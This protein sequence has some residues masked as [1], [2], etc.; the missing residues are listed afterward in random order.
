MKGRKN[1]NGEWSKNFKK[2]E[3]KEKDVKKEGTVKLEDGECNGFDSWS[4]TE[5]EGESEDEV[6]LAK[7]RKAKL[8]VP[9]NSVDRQDMVTIQNGGNYA[10]SGGY[11]GM[12]EGA[13]VPSYMPMSEGRAWEGMIPVGNVGIDRMEAGYPA[14]WGNGFSGVG[15][16]DQ[17]L[18]GRSGKPRKSV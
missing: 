1:E 18:L 11:Q 17:G 9:G 7:L 12:R 14:Y 4:G 8:S 3:D 16:W 10:C 15:A 13:A 2:V 5:S 6:P